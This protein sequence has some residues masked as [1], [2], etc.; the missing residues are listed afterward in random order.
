M[1]NDK[2]E[3]TW[4]PGGGPLPTRDPWATFATHGE[5][6]ATPHPHAEVSPGRA[7]WAPHVYR[8][9]RSRWPFVL[10]AVLVIAGVVIALVAACAPSPAR[11]AAPTGAAPV[12]TGWSWTPKVTP[13]AQRR[14]E[15]VD[16]LK[17]SKWRVSQAAEWLDRYTASNMVTVSRCSG[18]AWR[19]VYVRGG[20][21]PGNWLAVTRGNVITVDYGKVDRRGYR[22][23]SSREKILAHELFHTFAPGYGH[24]HS[25]RN[26]MRTTMGATSLYL[27]SGQRAI[28]RKL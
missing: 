19:C 10:G 18:R 20:K 24:S 2:G 16:Q 3:A 1:S 28:L 25:G 12:L 21:L 27:T 26:L 11:A 15:V 13:P 6:P 22:S 17:P 5:P 7:P 14:I 9:R 4:H 23:N 8:P